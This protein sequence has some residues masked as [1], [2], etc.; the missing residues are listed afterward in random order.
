MYPSRVQGALAKNVQS[1]QKKMHRNSS[2]EGVTIPKA[3]AGSGL[4]GDARAS[5][6]LGESSI[7][8]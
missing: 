2:G 8:V 7:R 3:G 6:V 4:V 1:P 5:G